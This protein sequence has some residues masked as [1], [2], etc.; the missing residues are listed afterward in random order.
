MSNVKWIGGAV[1]FALAVGLAAMAFFSAIFTGARIAGPLPAWVVI[2]VGALAIPA[3]AFGYS[4]T[5][6][7]W[8]VPA[9]WQRAGHLG[10]A[11]L[12]GF[13]LGLGVVTSLPSVGLV[14]L[15]ALAADA[16][17]FGSL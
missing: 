7:R 17:D 14:V 15:A 13:S 11:G 9:A 6:S 8:R 3:L 16:D 10:F 5:G 1:T 4:P 12:F 2:A